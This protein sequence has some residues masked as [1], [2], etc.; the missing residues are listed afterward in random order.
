MSTT[1]E[2]KV[3]NT[4]YLKTETILILE[5]EIIPHL[6]KK[7]NRKVQ[8][9]EAVHETVNFYKQNKHIFD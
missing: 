8:F 1:E 5:N 7:W 9:S 2:H 3:T 6:K 4:K